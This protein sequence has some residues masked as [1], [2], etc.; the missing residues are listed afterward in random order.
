MSTIKSHSGGSPNSKWGAVAIV[1]ILLISVTLFVVIKNPISLPEIDLPLF[2]KKSY[3]YEELVDYALILINNDRIDFGL[4]NVTLNEINS[5]QLHA[6][7][8][9][10]NNFFSHWDIDGYKP[11]MRY[12]LAGGTGSVSENCA[13]MY[14]SGL[15]DA[16]EVLKELEW[17]MMYNDSESDWGHKDNILTHFHNKVSIGISYDDNNLYLVQDFENDYVD[18]DILTVSGNEVHMKGTMVDKDLSIEHV[19][20]FYDNPMQL[21]PEQLEKPPYSGSYDQGTYVGLVLPSGWQAREGI[22][23]T[24]GVWFQTGN[25]FEIKFTI[26]EAPITHGEGVYTL[27]LQTNLENNSLVSYSIW[28]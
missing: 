28:Y 25:S 19:S 13:V 10:Q 18:W 7:N 24:S 26:S 20:I 9:L 21:T 2:S 16:K 1:A 23:I 27:Y 17:Q 4:E 14:T 3:T 6:D 5:A 12:T 8:M 15:I 11:Y 22:T